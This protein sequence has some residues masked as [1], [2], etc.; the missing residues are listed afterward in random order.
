[1]PEG[2]QP[3]RPGSGKGRGASRMPLTRLNT[4][5]VAPTPRASTRTTAAAKLGARRSR[6]TANRSSEESE[7]IAAKSTCR[8]T[9]A[10]VAGGKE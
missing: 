1:M 5:V 2:D 10:P 7:N 4:A 8:Y 6:R 3:A 9:S